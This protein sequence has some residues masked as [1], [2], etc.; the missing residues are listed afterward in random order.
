M[1]LFD[2]AHTL[3]IGLEL[4]FALCCSMGTLIRSILL[5]LRWIGLLLA[6]R[7]TVEPQ[8]GG[9]LHKVSSALGTLAQAAVAFLG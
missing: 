9:G 6:G 1:P 3:Q 4:P 5:G 2:L 7:P 8:A